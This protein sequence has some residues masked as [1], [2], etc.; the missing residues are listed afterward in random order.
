MSFVIAATTIAAVGTGYNV[1][2]G[3]RA[4]RM[5]KSAQADAAQQARIAAE[6]ADMAFNKANGKK[7]NL[8]G[9]FGANAAGANAGIGSTML[10]GPQ[11]VDTKSLLLGKNTLLGA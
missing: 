2:S 3:E 1:Y 11:G 10:T 8:A 5:Q 6:Q 9:I 4:A 7:P